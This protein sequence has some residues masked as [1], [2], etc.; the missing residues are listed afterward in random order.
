MIEI[1]VIKSS[2]DRILH[3]TIKGHAYFDN[4]GKDVVCSAV[5]ALT[6]GILN[7]VESILKIDLMPEENYQ[8]GG[9]LSWDIPKI[10]DNYTDDRLQLLM[11]VLVESL[12]MIEKEYKKYIKIII[13]TS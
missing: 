3:M 11:K 13:E 2:E 6:V 8:N 5:S 1:L 12:L 7:S 10:D 9:Y 4:P